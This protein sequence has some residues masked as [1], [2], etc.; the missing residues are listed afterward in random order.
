MPEASNVAR[1]YAE[2]VLRLA[3]EEK[4]IDSWRQELGKLDQLLDDQVLAAAFSNPGVGPQRRLELAKL[5]APDMRP[6]T[7]NF[8]RLLVEHQRTAQMPVIRQ[9]FNRLADE[10]LGLAHATL[11]TAVPLD[12]GERERYGRAL[13][14]R[15]GRK[16]ELRFATD[17]SLMGGATIRIGDRLVDGSVRTQL[18]RMRQELVG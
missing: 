13:E 18:E 15:L 17:P 12:Q 11:T 10:A 7:L 4:A 6:Q 2:G 1:R 3:Q 9:E 16:V 5:I 14:Q 8:L